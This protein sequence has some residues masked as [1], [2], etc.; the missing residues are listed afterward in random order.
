M[1]ALSLFVL[2]HQKTITVIMLVITLF[3]GIGA[4]QLERGF[5]MDQ[6]VPPDNPAM[7]LFD[8]IADYFPYASEYQEYILIEGDIATVEALDGI[9]L[10]LNNMEDDS[11]IGRNKD[12]TIKADSLYHIIV[13]AVNNNNT[14]IQAFNLDETT[15]IPDSDNDVR[16]L[17]D[18]LLEGDT[19]SF[20]SFEQDEDEQETD[21]AMAMN[22]AEMVLYRNQS[23]YEATIIRYYL[24]ASF[25]IDGGNLQ[26]DLETLSSE[27]KEDL[28]DYGSAT[29]IATG[30]S[31]IQ[32]QNTNQLTSSQIISTGISVVLAAFVL[33]ITFRRPVLG[34]ITMVPVC[35]SIVWILGTMYYL[36]YI[37]DIMTVMVTSITIGIGIDYAIH[38]TQRFKIVAARTGDINKAVCATI[39]HTGGA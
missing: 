24:D 16:R 14:L 28:V 23:R 32:L 20:P 1:G 38:A 22:E 7:E 31:N 5:D 15:Y 29:A 17:Y 37:L 35:I 8:T 25:Q 26:D 6:F 11:F 18:Y 13:E 21:E 34:I 19:F 2:S 27:M 4:L 12:N 3:F 30:L 39:G 36:G 10:T 9:R 33:V